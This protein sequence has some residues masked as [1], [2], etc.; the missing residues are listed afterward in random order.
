MYQLAPLALKLLPFAIAATVLA[1]G[2]LYVKNL[3]ETV[4]E[5]QVRLEKA[6][7]D[8][9]VLEQQVKDLSVQKAQLDANL[10]EAEANRS[11]IRADLDATLRKLRNQKP[12]IECKAAVEWSIQNKGDLQW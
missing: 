1:G 10:V 11:K 9:L 7:E 12:P 8:K 6:E 4:V 2:Y 5:Q 3:Q